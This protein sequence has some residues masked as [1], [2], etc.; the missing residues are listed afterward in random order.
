MAP[1]TV[2][3]GLSALE[4]QGYIK[5]D[6]RKASEV[7]YKS[8]P[9]MQRRSAAEYFVP[10][11]KAIQDLLVSSELLFGACWALRL[12]QLSAGEWE[13]FR[14]SSEQN[15]DHTVSVTFQFCLMALR[16]L[17]NSLILNLY[18]EVLRFLKFPYLTEDET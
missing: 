10:G 13:K 11:K 5:I 14:S 3:V 6:A 1:A 18:W 2:R 4:K 15:T 9:A 8:D 7:I 16:A 12:N 17:D